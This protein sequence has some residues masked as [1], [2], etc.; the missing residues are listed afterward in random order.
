MLLRYVYNQINATKTK[1][2]KEDFSVKV[3]LVDID[4]HGMKATIYP[5]ILKSARYSKIQ[6]VKSLVASYYVKDYLRPLITYLYDQE[7]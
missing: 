7:N 4:L 3:F 6:I 2:D 5:L 1:G